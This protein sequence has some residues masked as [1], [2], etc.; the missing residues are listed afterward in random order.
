MPPFNI[1]FGWGENEKI[2][3][4]NVKIVYCKKLDKSIP[5]F[6]SSFDFLPVKGVIYHFFTLCVSQPTKLII[7]L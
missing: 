4:E 3:D 1:C 2:K 7:Y 5:K 6:N